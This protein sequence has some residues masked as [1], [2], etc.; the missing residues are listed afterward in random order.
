MEY[1]PPLEGKKEKRSE[2]NYRYFYCSQTPEEQWICRHCETK[3]GCEPPLYNFQSQK[4]NLISISSSVPEF[5][6]HLILYQ[7]LSSSKIQ[8][9]K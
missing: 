6:D 2:N 8:I 1:K 3:E 4:T 5:F 9:E 7:K